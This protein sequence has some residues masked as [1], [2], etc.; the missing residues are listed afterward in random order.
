[1][2]K[3]HICTVVLILYVLTGCEYENAEEK[4]YDAKGPVVVNNNGLLA[5]ITFDKNISDKSEN[6]SAVALQGDAEYVKGVDGKDSSAIKLSGYPQCIAVSNIGYNDTLSIFLWFKTEQ[7]LTKNDKFTLFDYGVNSFSMQIDG[8][9]GSTLL[10]T[11]H[12]NE[13]ATM[14]DWINSFNGWNYLYAESGSGKFK[15]VY[16][17]VMKN[18]EVIEI[19]TEN[20]SIGALLPVADMLYIGRS[21]GQNTASETYF[22]GSI[23]NIRV[24]NRPLSKSELLALIN[25]DTQH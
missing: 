21:G 8:S 17:G 12:N 5:H 9:T 23:D 13:K 6:K 18:N 7:A 10:N 3:K 2:I 14:E 4:Y 20:E 15:V 25:N 24:Y 16:K 22:T 11:I 1:M 19:D